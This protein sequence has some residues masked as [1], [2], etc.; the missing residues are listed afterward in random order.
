MIKL[1]E[2]TPTARLLWSNDTSNEDTINPD[3]AR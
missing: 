3:R 1:D 2:H